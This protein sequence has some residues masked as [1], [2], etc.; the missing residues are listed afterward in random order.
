MM[1]KLI[2][3]AKKWGVLV[4]IAGALGVSGFFEGLRPVFAFQLEPYIQLAQSNSD[5]IALQRWQY[6]NAKSQNQG[7]DIA[8]QL[9]YCK[10]SARLGLLGQGCA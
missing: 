9:E 4:V 3:L 1:D 8:E 6:L 2:T 5:A 10:L 7:L